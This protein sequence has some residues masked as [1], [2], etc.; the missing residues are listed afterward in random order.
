MLLLIRSITAINYHLVLR[1]VV[2]ALFLVFVVDILHPII[3]LPPQPCNHILDA[4]VP[5]RNRV[6]DPPRHIV[7]LRK[8]A[9]HAPVP[10][11]AQLASGIGSPTRG[12]SS[13]FTARRPVLD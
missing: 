5:L 8:H 4:F 6:V 1:S 10:Q 2:A 7:A 12:K 13:S 9:I 11:L 3:Q